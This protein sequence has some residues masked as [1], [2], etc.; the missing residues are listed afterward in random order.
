MMRLLGAHFFTGRRQN[1]KAEI[2]G[3]VFWKRE[4]ISEG[5]A[6]SPG[7]PETR[8]PLRRKRNIFPASRAR[9]VITH[10]WQH[11]S[12]L[13]AAM[14][15]LSPASWI[16]VCSVFNLF[17]SHHCVQG[18]QGAD[19]LSFYSQASQ[20]RRAATKILHL[21]APRAP[22]VTHIVSSGTSGLC[23]CGAL[24]WEFW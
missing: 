23:H 17:L 14:C 4:D 16:Q 5:G 6:K 10:A 24:L 20:S 9:C 7:E 15:L 13:M 22:G 12:G 18:V 2:M 11:F 19:Y 3:Y 8:E 1:E 21:E